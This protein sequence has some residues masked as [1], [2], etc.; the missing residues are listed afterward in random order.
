LFLA[1]PKDASLHWFVGLGGD[2]IRTW[3]QMCGTFLKKYKDYFKARELREEIF[4]MT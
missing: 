4:K 3:E 2:T 1:T